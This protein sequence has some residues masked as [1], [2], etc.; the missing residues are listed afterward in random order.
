MIYDT[1]KM[2]RVWSNIRENLKNNMGTLP[3]DIFESHW[4]AFEEDIA[5]LR[6][7]LKKSCCCVFDHTGE[8]TKV[9]E[10][11]KFHGEL[12]SERD[13]YK[14]AL[15]RIN[16]ESVRCPEVNDEIQACDVMKGI[17]LNALINSPCDT[18]NGEGDKYADI[19]NGCEKMK[20]GK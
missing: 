7:K 6:S 20:R 14:E 11:C 5:E 16:N 12:R 8:K 18:C 19:C 1:E 13:K 3:R 17:A 2:E 4:M 15:E 10:W 9:V